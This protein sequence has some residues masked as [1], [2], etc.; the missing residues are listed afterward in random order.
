MVDLYH[1]HKDYNRG[2][3]ALVDI[4]L[5]VGRGEFFYLTCISGAGMTTLLSL[6]FRAETVTSG[7]SL[8]DGLNVTKLPAS[9]VPPIRRRLGLDSQ[10]FK[11]LPRKTVYE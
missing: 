4:S 7:K 9:R 11:L 6:L 2:S 10:D 3:H 1:V 8:S 5:T